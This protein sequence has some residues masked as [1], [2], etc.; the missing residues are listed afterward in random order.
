MKGLV[1]VNYMLPA[2]QPQFFLPNSDRLV[3]AVPINPLHATASRGIC[4]QIMHA[5]LCIDVGR[6]QNESTAEPSCSGI[7]LRI[8]GRGTAAELI[9]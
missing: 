7:R 4:I 6:S 5:V 3:A 9:N 1:R 8:R 2:G